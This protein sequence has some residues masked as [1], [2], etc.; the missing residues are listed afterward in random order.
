MVFAGTLRLRAGQWFLERK[1][2]RRPWAEV[3]GVAGEVFAI[4]VYSAGACFV[5]MLLAAWVGALARVLSADH[6]HTF[7]TLDGMTLLSASA[8]ASR[9]QGGLVPVLVS[10]AALLLLT[11]TGY[12]IA[13]RA[14]PVAAGILGY[15]HLAPPSFAVTTRVSALSHWLV[16]F[17]SHLRG[18]AIQVLI[19]SIAIAYVLQSSAVSVSARLDQVRRRPG[20]G[21]RDGPPWLDVIRKACAT[22]L[23][24]LVLLMATWAA[25]VVR[26]AAASGAGTRSLEMSYGFQGGLYQSKYLLVLAFIAVCLS[27]VYNADKW[28]VAAV[29]LTAWYGLAP[30]AVTWPSALE[31]SVGRGLLTRAGTEWGADSLWAALFIF[32]PAVMLGIYLVGRLM[33][34]R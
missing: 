16:S 29:L 13:F 23:V 24:L 17:D 27:Q 1:V 33:R 20:R 7:T 34:S 3:A 28:L 11:P 8:Q 5:S 9:Y 18:D 14:A 31:I 15:L 2:S 6:W 32:A 22:L 19:F 12:T 4:R 10:W 30:T 26:L 21:S 25:T